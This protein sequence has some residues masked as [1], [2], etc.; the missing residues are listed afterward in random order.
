MGIVKRLHEAI[1][2]S[3]LVLVDTSIFGGGSNVARKIYGARVPLELIPFETELY[4]YHNIWNSQ[5]K[6]ISQADNVYTIPEVFGELEKFERILK[7]SLG[8]HQKKINKNG[9]HKPH[10][11]HPEKPSLPVEEN[12]QTPTALHLVNSL[13][14]DVRRTKSLVRLYQGT[15]ARYPKDAPAET[16]YLLVGAAVGYSEANPDKAVTLVSKD[17]K[18]NTTI[19][20]Y[21]LERVVNEVMERMRL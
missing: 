20:S 18:I 16:D 7:E 13:I 1:R 10:I 8:W 9:K 21:V 19:Q 12:Y 3:D 2:D 5:L 14:I 6:L 15:I 11:E 4:K 17:R